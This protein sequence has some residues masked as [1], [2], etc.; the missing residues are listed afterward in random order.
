M[1]EKWLVFYKCK[2]FLPVGVMSYLT[3]AM[4]IIVRIM[5]AFNLWV[6][7]AMLVLLIVVVKIRAS[8]L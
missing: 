4:F 2:Y 6:A 3:I 1:K 5:D 7:L 8:L